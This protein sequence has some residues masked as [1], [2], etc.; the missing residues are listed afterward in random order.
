[1]SRKQKSKRKPAN[2]KRKNRSNQTNQKGFYIGAIGFILL[3][4]WEIVLYRQTFIS[5]WTA[6]VIYIIGGLI[7]FFLLKSR[8]RNYKRRVETYGLFWTILAGI[9]F[10]G[11]IV[12]TLVM[13]LNYYIPSGEQAESVRLNVVKTG[14]FG[15][16]RG[17]HDPYVIVDYNG[18]YK[19]LVLNQNTDV[20][21]CVWV[22]ASL[23]KGIFGF[24]TAKNMVL[25]Y[26]EPT[27]EVHAYQKLLQ[28]ANQYE[29]L[30]NKSKAIEL[31]Q[32]A[33]QLNPSDS[34]PVNHLV[35]LKTSL[36]IPPFKKS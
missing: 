20:N 16:R 19:Q 2:S 28:R 33:V 15:G 25:G 11:G 26:S 13:T 18:T 29:K 12:L 5:F 24:R 9:F 17:S 23:Y 8:M 6:S 10:S 14:R 35:K 22:K 27:D 34:L 3:M 31:Y 36:R 21:N 1:M 4:L 32:R 7:A 30:G